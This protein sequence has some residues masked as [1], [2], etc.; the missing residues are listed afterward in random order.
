VLAN[1]IG[2]TGA[3]MVLIR[4]LLRANETRTHR[5]HIIV[6]FIFVV[7]NCGGLLTPLGDPPLYLGYLKGVPFEWTLHLW[8]EWALVNGVLLFIFLAVDS[9]KLDKEELER[10]GAQ[11]EDALHHMRFGIEG[12]KNIVLMFLLIGVILARSAGVLNHGTPWPFGVQQ[13][14]MFGLAWLSWTWTSAKIHRHNRFGFGPII[15]VVVLFAGI[16]VTMVEPLQ[17]LNARGAELG[18]TQPWQFFWTTGGLSALLDNA[19]TYLTIAAAASGAAG[20]PASSPTFLGEFIARTPENAKILAAIS[21]GAVFMGAMTYIGNGPNF[22]VKAIAEE[23]GIKM[24]SFFP[25]VLWSCCVLLPVL[26]V[27]AFVFF[28]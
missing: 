12:G 16:F 21:C 19:P 26:A 3:S 10:P 18:L 24:P 23:S 13:A 8:K 2:T 15:E 7:S 27:A 9:F 28:V 5:V 4:P 6:F 11:L 20:V 22:M 14:L 1:L 25:Y 17:I